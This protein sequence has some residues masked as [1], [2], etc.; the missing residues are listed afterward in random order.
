[1]AIISDKTSLASFGLLGLLAS[2]A[3][4]ILDGVD[5]SVGDL[6]W[7]EG[8]RIVLKVQALQ[9]RKRTDFRRQGVDA[10]LR[11]VKGFGGSGWI[12]TTGTRRSSA[13]AGRR[14][15]PDSATLPS[16]S[17]GE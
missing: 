15:K 10:L 12:R 5:S 16:I 6:P 3:K 14:N 9:V 2:F 1:M 7:R 11:Q 8:E 4:P 17:G 13:L